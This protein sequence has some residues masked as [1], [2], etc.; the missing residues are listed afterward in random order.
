MANNRFN[1]Q[2]SPK[3]YKEGG[4]VN[5]KPRKMPSRPLPEGKIKPVPMP[6]VTPDP[7]F[8]PAPMPKFTPEKKVVTPK[9]KRRLKELLNAKRKKNKKEKIKSVTKKVVKTMV[10]GLGAALAAKKLIKKMSG[11]GGK[12]KAS[13]K[14]G[15]ASKRGTINR[16]PKKTI[17]VIET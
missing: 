3:G 9:M 10:P 11:R 5:I 16:R 2:V 1:T 6:K 4:S 7:K 12:E 8:K 17:E 14:M 15:G 13:R